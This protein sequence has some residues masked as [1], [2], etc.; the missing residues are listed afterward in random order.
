MPYHYALDMVC[1]LIRSHYRRYNV[2]TVFSLVSSYGNILSA[3]TAL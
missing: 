3:P 2:R 1:T